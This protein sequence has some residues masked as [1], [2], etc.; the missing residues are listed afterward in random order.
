MKFYKLKKKAGY[1]FLQPVEVSWEEVLADLIFTVVLFLFITS[2][3][4][5]IPGVAEAVY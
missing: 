1:K 3:V 4:M 5:G 2:I